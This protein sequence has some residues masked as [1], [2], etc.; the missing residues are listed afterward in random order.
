MIGY[1]KTPDRR[2]SGIAAIADKRF[3]FTD[4]SFGWLVKDFFF[5]G[6]LLRAAL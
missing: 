3:Q 4:Y 5:R 1:D 2:K 6:R